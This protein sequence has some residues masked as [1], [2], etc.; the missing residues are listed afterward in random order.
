M[1][2][3]SKLGPKALCIVT[4]CPWL[5]FRAVPEEEEQ[6]AAKEALNREGCRWTIRLLGLVTQLVLAS[7]MLLAF[8]ASTS[9]LTDKCTWV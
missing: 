7:N 6:P 4:S 5:P 1:R 2:Q 8:L 3:Q 9:V